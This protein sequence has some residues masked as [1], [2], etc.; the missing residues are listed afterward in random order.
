MNQEIYSHFFL[1]L[2]NV[3]V[4]FNKEVYKMPFTVCMHACVLVCLCVWV[5]A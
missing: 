1:T 4:A 5:C 2:Q 3:F